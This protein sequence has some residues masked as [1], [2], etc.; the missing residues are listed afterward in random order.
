MTEFK[1]GDIVKVV[2][3]KIP[4]QLAGYIQ[5]MSQQLNKIGKIEHYVY[6]GAVR[7]T[8]TGGYVWDIR[9]L[10]LVDGEINKKEEICAKIRYLE[11]KFKN[12]K[13]IK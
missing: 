6:S 13:N 11:E 2:R 5:S 7:V 12:R 8:N 4:G 1:V 3:P 9:C 10:E